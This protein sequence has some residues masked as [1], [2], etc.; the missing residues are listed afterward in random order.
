M[1]SYEYYEVFKSSF[2]VHTLVAVSVSPRSS[3][4]ITEK[5]RFFFGFLIRYLNPLMP[6][7]NKK[8][9]HT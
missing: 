6:G 9:T 3:V 1:F 7:G 2:F 4:E 8:V 5:T